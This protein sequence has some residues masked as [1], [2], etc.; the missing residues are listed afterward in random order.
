ME[1]RHAGT[2]PLKTARLH[3]RRLRADDAEDMLENWANDPEVTRFLT[4]DAYTDVEKVRAYL[5]V[6]A[7]TYESDRVYN[8]GIEFQGKLIGTIGI[9][10]ADLDAL[11]CWIGYCIGRRWWGMGLTAE[12]LAAV[13]DYLFAQIGFNR[14]AAMHDARNPGSGRVMQKAG[15][16][17]E[18]ILRQSKRDRDGTLIDTTYYSILREEWAHG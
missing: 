8:W 10:R 11:A 16:T 5:M 4:W 2:I 6:Q 3:L 14:V 1:L 15:M 12:A 18:G 13:R 9:V 17:F 7:E